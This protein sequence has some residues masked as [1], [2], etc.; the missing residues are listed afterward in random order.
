FFA[1]RRSCS[2][3]ILVLPSSLRECGRS[4]L[5]RSVFPLPSPP[6]DWR[7]R[8]SSTGRNSKR[9]GPSWSYRCNP[10]FPRPESF[11]AL[12]VPRFVAML[13]ACCREKDTFR[14]RN[15][16]YKRHT[17]RWRW[18]GAGGNA[19]GGEVAAAVPVVSGGYFRRAGGSVEQRDFGG[20]R[21]DRPSSR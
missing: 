7:N 9:T 2:R 17:G 1:P 18:F 3:R 4:E 13:I 19:N 5:S 12:V 21:A 6:R 20:T 8:G 11:R 16:S 15:F 14:Y 10:D